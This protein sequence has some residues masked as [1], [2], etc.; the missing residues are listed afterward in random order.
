MNSGTIR[1]LGGVA[2]V[3]VAVLFGL[4]GAVVAFSPF[5]GLADDQVAG[6]LYYVGG[7]LSVLALP[8]IL[9]ASERRLG[10]PG[11]VGFAMAQTGIVMYAT[12]MFLILP[13]VEDVSGAHD[14]FLFAAAEVPVFP[15]GALMF[16]VG[17]AMLGFAVAGP[18]SV[19]RW[20]WGA[21]LFA[22]GSL[23][24]LVAF[25]GVVWLLFV[26]NL[27]AGTGMVALG[28]TMVAGQSGSAAPGAD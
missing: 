14:V 10:W 18:R 1:R 8:A 25:F 6:G 13:L 21:R 15:I 27:I 23:C 19:P 11:L 20:R 12:G 24:W 5:G 7:V 9:S 17:C 16:F 4:G 2:I 28:L 22:V 3:L 26:A